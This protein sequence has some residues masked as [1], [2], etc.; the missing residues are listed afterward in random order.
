MVSMPAEN[1]YITRAIDRLWEVISDEGYE[2]T[3]VYGGPPQLPDGYIEIVRTGPPNTAWAVYDI[4]VCAV[5]R[6]GND[7]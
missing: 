7:Q 1:V 6:K 2:V 4:R 5:P 3:Q